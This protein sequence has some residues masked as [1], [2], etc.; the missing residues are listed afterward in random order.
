[1]TPP[2]PAPAGAP[3]P[4]CRARLRADLNLAVVVADDAV[5]DRQAEAAALRERA[6]ERLEERVELLG[7]DADALRRCTVRTTPSVDG[8]TAPTR[9]S[10][11]PSGM[12]RRPLVARFQTICLICPSSASYHSSVG[13]T[14]TLDLVPVEHLGAV[15]Q[16]QRRVVERAAHVEPRDLEALRPRV[17]EKRSDRRVQALRLAQHDVHQ[18]LLL[19][20]ERQLL[21]ED[22]DGAGHR[23]ERVAD[24]VRDAGGHLADRG[25]PL[26][27]RRVA[28][29]LLDGGHVLEREQ[30]PGASAR[31]F[32]VRRGQADLEL[33]APVDRP[34]AELV[35]PARALRP[36]VALNRRHRPA[37]AAA[38]RRRSARPTAA[39]TAR[40]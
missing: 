19:A 8:S 3:T 29:E 31:R 34:V 39:G 33:A 16:Q 13:G 22:L 5:H 14:S 25:Q 37:A 17:G 23:R 35:A 9:R 10:R 36:Q 21:A 4:S 12:A 38:A 28:L 24:L 26:L 1:M 32:Q 27:N 6:V 20:A 30:E 18:L 11:P 2:P 7:R 15:A 40:R